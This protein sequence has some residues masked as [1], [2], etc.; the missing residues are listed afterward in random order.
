MLVSIYVLNGSSSSLV[1]TFIYD[2]TLSS[3]FWSIQLLRS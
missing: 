2:T 1:Q 3:K